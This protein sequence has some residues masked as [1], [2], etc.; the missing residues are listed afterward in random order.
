MNPQNQYHE[1]KE[2]PIESRESRE[3]REET[4]SS[5]STDIKISSMNPSEV[6]QLYQQNLDLQTY[7][8]RAQG[9]I[10]RLNQELSSKQR[11]LSSKQRD[12]DQAQALL[13]SQG[14]GPCVDFD[15]GST[16]LIETLKSFVLQLASKKLNLEKELKERE[17]QLH[18]QAHN[19]YA[20]EVEKDE[21]TRRA[22]ER[23]RRNASDLSTYGEFFRGVMESKSPEE[24]AKAISDLRDRVHL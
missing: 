2:E 13:V 7:C 19:N 16:Q 8:L 1:I 15:D 22:Q 18:N 17:D 23:S 21:A 20:R 24:T 3:N 12:L 11:D 5:D 9:E 14:S 6:E 10:D 4:M